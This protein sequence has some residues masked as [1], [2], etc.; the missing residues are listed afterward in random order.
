MHNKFILGV[1]LLGLSLVVQPAFAEEKQGAKSKKTTAQSEKCWKRVKPFEGTG[2][3]PVCVAF[4]KL[5][6][7][8]CEPPEKLKCNWSLP[9]GEKRFK[10]LKWL[11]LDWKEYL[12]LIGD[13][14]KSG[15]REDMR[16]GLWKKE[17]PRILKLFEEGKRS[18]AITTVD[19]DHDGNKEQIVRY[20]LIP[21]NETPG[22]MFGVML[23]ETKRLDWR[24]EHLL[25]TAN[26]SE[27]AEIML[28]DGRAFMFGWDYAWKQVDIWEGFPYGRLNVCTFKYIKGG[29]RQ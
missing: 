20:D 10:K 17:E 3:A 19:I 8:T 24:F 6:N 25:N 18:I 4:E 22:V 16:E 28:F 15:V 7:T 29:I 27:G 2:N 5:L 23:P 21:C 1:M 12:E 13:I 9:V 11:P 26:A 14:N